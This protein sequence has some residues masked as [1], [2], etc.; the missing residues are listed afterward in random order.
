MDFA[1]NYNISYQSLNTDTFFKLP[2]LTRSH[3]KKHASERGAQTVGYAPTPIIKR[4]IFN[5]YHKSITLLSQIITN[6]L[7][8]L[9]TDTKLTYCILYIF[10][11]PPTRIERV[12][13][14]LGG[15]CS[16]H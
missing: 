8:P 12:T 9:P 13:L 4:V 16:I 3:A 14:P 2:A 7:Q 5:S 6:F 15:G 10:L 11:V 1:H